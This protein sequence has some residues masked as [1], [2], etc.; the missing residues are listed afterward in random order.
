MAGGH[1]KISTGHIDS[2]FGISVHQI[3]HVH[4]IVDAYS[5]R[6]HGIHMHT[7]WIILDPD[8]FREE[9]KSARN[10]TPFSDLE[11]ID[12]GSGFKVPYKPDDYYTDIQSFGH[13][14]S[15]RFRQFSKE[16]AEKL[17]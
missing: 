9:L 17:E 7:G 15:R 12:F 14:L 4:R 5:I 1:D 6:I 16:Y 8:V 2:K 10:S 3:A 11:Y 13:V